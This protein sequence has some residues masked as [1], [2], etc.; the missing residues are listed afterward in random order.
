MHVSVI[1]PTRNRLSYLKRAIRSV[2]LQ[3]YQGWDLW[4]I[5][6]G[7]TDGT[8]TWV[9]DELIFQ[10][11]QSSTKS[12]PHIHSPPH[13]PTP[14]THSPIYY[15]RTPTSLGVSHA[16]NLGIQLSQGPWVAFLDSDDEWLPHKLEKQVQWAQESSLHI[17]HG[18]E[19]W[20]RHNTRVNPKKKHQKSGGRIFKRSVDICCISP[21]TVMIHKNLFLTEGLFKE[22]FPVCEDYDLWLRL[23][24]KYDVGF[25]KE[26]L[27]KKYGG[28]KDQLSRQ[29]VAM[30]Y[31]RVRSLMS[32]KDAPYLSDNENDYLKKSLRERARLLIQGY[33]KHNNTNHLQEIERIFAMS[34]E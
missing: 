17:V 24:A 20:F 6:D 34:Y 8:S 1:I 9:L 28:H 23:S 18:E 12:L 15:V 26:P 21:S 32:L 10:G 11:T 29:Y 27:I 19:I 33:K 16:R 3:S 31:W 30:D 14:S 5:D 2:M 4:I 13:F 7:S 25:I 22:S